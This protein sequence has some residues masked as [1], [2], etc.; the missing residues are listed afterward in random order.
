MSVCEAV[1]VQEPLCKSLGCEVY[2][3]KVY[4]VGEVHENTEL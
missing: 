4:A 1:F 2:R 3:V